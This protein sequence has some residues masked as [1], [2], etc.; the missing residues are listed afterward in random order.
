MLITTLFIDQQIIISINLFILF[1]PLAS[2]SFK[3][4]LEAVGC[5]GLEAILQSALI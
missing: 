4:H 5:E 2:I 1:L 3:A